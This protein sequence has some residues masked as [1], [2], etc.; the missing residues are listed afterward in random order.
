MGFAV[1]DVSSTTSTVEFDWNCF[2]FA[3]WV[4][5]TFQVHQS[6]VSTSTVAMKSVS[7]WRWT[8]EK[9]NTYPTTRNPV[10]P[11][12]S[13]QCNWLQSSPSLTIRLLPTSARMATSC[14]FISSIPTLTRAT[15]VRLHHLH[16]NESKMFIRKFQIKKVCTVVSHWR[17]DYSKQRQMKYAVVRVMWAKS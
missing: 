10:N 6:H 4:T 15:H 11:S 13:S 5:A 2:S 7:G 16:A 12:N 17:A 14:L 3:N 8:E 1:H 9:G